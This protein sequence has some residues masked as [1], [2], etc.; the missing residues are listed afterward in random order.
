M[1]NIKDACSLR[2]WCMPAVFFDDKGFRNKV[3]LTKEHHNCTKLIG[4][5]EEEAKEEMILLGCIC[6]FCSNNKCIRH[7]ASKSLIQTASF[8]KNC[9]CKK[10][11]VRWKVCLPVLRKKE[12]KKFVLSLSYEEKLEL[13]GHLECLFTLTYISNQPL[14]VKSKETLESLAKEL[15]VFTPKPKGK[16]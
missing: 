8:W 9:Q 15:S 1:K 5:T 14:I 7:P 11:H 2:G 3:C 6:K 12:E 4:R 16:G 10:C 13:A